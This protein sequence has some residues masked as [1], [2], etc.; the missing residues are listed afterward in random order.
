MGKGEKNASPLHHHIP[1]L[2]RICPRVK[3]CRASA[4]NGTASVR[5]RNDPKKLASG[6]AKMVN[7]DYTC[8][9]L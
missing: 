3:N 8:G 6:I 4:T 5:Y 7:R 9:E 1:T 2:S